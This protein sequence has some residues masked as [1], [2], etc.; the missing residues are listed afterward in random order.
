VHETLKLYGNLL[1]PIHYTEAKDIVRQSVRPTPLQ[2]GVAWP[3]CPPLGERGAS[4]TFLG[5]GCTINVPY[6][7]VQFSFQ[8]SSTSIFRPTALDRC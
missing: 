5:N 2:L 7:L 4:P 6:T 1:S 3:G 8:A